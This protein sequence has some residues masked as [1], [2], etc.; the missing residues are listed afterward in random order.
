MLR[1]WRTIAHLRR[2]SSL[3]ARRL[4][5]EDSSSRGRSFVGF[6]LSNTHT[7][8]PRFGMDMTHAPGYELAAEDNPPSVGN[9]KLIDFA[10]RHARLSS[11]EVDNAK[12]YLW[13]GHV[14]YPS[15]VAPDGELACSWE[16]SDDIES[17]VDCIEEEF[18]PDPNSNPEPI[19]QAKTSRASEG[20]KEEN[21]KP[22]VEAKRRYSGGQARRIRKEREQNAI[23]RARA[24]RN[25]KRRPIRKPQND[26]PE[27]EDT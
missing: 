14:L 2:A 23:R 1:T 7:V 5:H 10:V 12:G 13:I 24:K 21:E 27:E 9:Q 3:H 11:A 8:D 26:I 17:Q 16:M 19:V 6:S 25:H 18:E 15:G 20:A 22:I 4:L